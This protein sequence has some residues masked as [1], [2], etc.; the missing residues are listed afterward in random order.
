ML[1]PVLADA[2]LPADLADALDE[3]DRDG[4]QAETDEALGAHRQGRRDAD[5][6]VRARRDGT[7][8]SAR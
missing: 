5:P 2:G 7:R 4:I 6:A 1:E 3:T 8:S